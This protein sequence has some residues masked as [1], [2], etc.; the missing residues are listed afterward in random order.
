MAVKNDPRHTSDRQS[1][2]LYNMLR[3]R[4]LKISACSDTYSKIIFRPL[5]TGTTAVFTFHNFLISVARSCYF[6][7]FSLLQFY[8][9]VSWDY[10]YYHYYY[11]YYYYYYHYYYY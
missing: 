10:Y 2:T 9:P 1:L 8:L 6:S 5:M 4:R 7:V 3:D 11:Y